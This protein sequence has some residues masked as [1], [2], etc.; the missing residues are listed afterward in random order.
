MNSV[1][2]NKLKPSSYN[3]KQVTLENQVHPFLGTI[4]INKITHSD[5][6]DMINELVER[7]LSYSTIKKAYEAVNAC[8]REY[9]IRTGEYFNPCEGIAKTAKS[10]KAGNQRSQ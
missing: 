8:C 9:R 7:G 2:K 4:P 3:R 1:L 5:I 6:Q 10:S